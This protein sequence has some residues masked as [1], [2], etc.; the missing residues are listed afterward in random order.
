MNK[1]KLLISAILAGLC[2]SFSGAAYL[3]V[4]SKILGAFLFTFGLFAI[5][6]MGFH[7]YTG[8]VCYLFDNDLSYVY[9]I[10]II[11]L[12]NLIGTFT[13]AK[14]HLCTRYGYTLATNAST[15]CQIK[16]SDN[17]FS[18]FILAIF[19]NALIYFAVDGFIN[20]K[21]ELGKYLALFFGVV[22]F[23]FCGFEHCIAN[24]YYFTIA[25][26]WSLRTILY[27]LVMSLGNAVGGIF[28]HIAHQYISN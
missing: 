11:W 18:I 3:S 25:G 9:D 6:T 5:C 13:G 17:L 10:L 1:I 24:M 28:F 22:V 23:I 8:K 26:V 14:L 27:L 12:G 19:C 20:N 16:L 21:H 15:I 4:D 7:L 2:I